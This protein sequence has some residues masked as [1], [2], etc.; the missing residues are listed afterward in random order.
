MHPAS[1]F[2]DHDELEEV[3]AV[4]GMIAKAE[5]EFA[6]PLALL[7]ARI[8]SLLAHPVA[9][10]TNPLGPLCLCQS[11]VDATRSA[12]I[13]I[14]AKLVLFKLFDRHVVK[15]GIGQSVSSW[16]MNYWW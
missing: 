1:R 14:K 10:K 2:V 3:V 9:I 4:E 12:D 8:D 6:E 13:D 11:F 5:K 7:T 16:P 15:R